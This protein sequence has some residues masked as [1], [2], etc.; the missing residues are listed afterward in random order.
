MTME[1]LVIFI[2]KTVYCVLVSTEILVK[3]I[4][5]SSCIN[6]FTEFA[7]MRPEIGFLTLTMSLTTSASMFVQYSKHRLVSASLQLTRV[8]P[9]T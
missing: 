6:S 2:T 7:T 3:S 1:T 5:G 9:S 8:S 4:A